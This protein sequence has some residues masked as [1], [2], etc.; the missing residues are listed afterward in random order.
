VQVGT[1]VT[2]G[3]FILPGPRVVNTNFAALCQHVSSLGRTQ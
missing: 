2:H 1:K 3:L